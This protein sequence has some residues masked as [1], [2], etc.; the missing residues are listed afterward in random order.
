MGLQRDPIPPED[1]AAALERIRASTY[2]LQS[3]RLSSFLRFAVEKTLRGESDDLKEYRIATEVYGRQSDFDPAGDSIVRSE[4]RRLRRKLK[5]YYESEGKDDE[6]VIFFRP[7]SYVPITRWRVSLMG[8][9]PPAKASPLWSE[10]D[11]VR[12]MVEAFQSRAADELASSCA[13]GITEELLHQLIRVPGI[14]AIS[15]SSGQPDA[16]AGGAAEPLI[17]IGGSVRSEP[18][19]LRVNARIATSDGMTLWSQRFDASVD[20]GATLRLQ[21][22]AATALLSRVSPRTSIVRHRAG[23]PTRTLLSLYTEVLAAEALLEDGSISAIEEALAKF[24][25]MIARAPEFARLHAGVTQCCVSLAQRGV[26]NW[27]ELG[28][29]GSAAAQTALEVDPKMPDAHLAKACVLAGQWKW[30]Q[31]EESFAAALRL[32]DIHS[33]HRQFGQFL[34]SQLRF[35]EAWEHLKIAEEMDPFS[36]RQRT[37]LARFFYYSR[38]YGEAAAFYKD[39]ER[40][41]QLPLEV[42]A[43]RAMTAI[44][45][46][47]PFTP[48]ALA[49]EIR[50][51]ARHAGT[52]YLAF[53]AEILARCGELESARSL[54]HEAGLL[55]PRAGLCDFRQ[56]S[57]ALALQDRTEGLR[58]LTESWKHR[59]P[60]LPWLAADPRFDDIRDEPEYRMIVQAVFGQKL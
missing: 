12:V 53:A 57:L 56:A 32:G 21:E 49:G 51:A 22:A 52:V 59:E 46:G 20:D 30:K 28:G 55:T 7:G 4:A 5:E 50:Q 3:T 10:G 54:A 45:A 38:R 17:L 25:G 14:R 42:K 16:D 1:V 24:E 18:G 19:M 6:V 34:S 31:A 35:D 15:K 33:A 23:A 11:G 36:A 13:F 47:D 9:S 39:L 44:L 48:A 2:F 60:E 27:R 40:Q 8:E 29:K 58:L 43:I 41:G 26:A 37:S